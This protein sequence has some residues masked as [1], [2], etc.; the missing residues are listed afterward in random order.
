MNKYKIFEFIPLVNVFPLSFDTAYMSSS[1]GNS[2][3][4]FFYP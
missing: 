1:L 4:M 3:I 2:T